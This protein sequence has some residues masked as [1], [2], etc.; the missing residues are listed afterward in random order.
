MATS[1]SYRLYRSAAPLSKRRPVSRVAAELTADVAGDPEPPAFA[2][3]GLDSGQGAAGQG[4]GTRSRRH[5]WKRVL[6]YAGGLAA[7]GALAYAGW[8]ALSI[9]QL[10]QRIYRPIPTLTPQQVAEGEPTTL[11]TLAPTAR[12]GSANGVATAA[13]TSTPDALAALPRGRVNILVLGTDKRANDPDHFPRSDTM[14]L[15]NLDTVSETVRVLSLPRD[16]VVEI[17]DYGRSKLN[18]AYLF[19]EYYDVPGGGQAVAVQTV[20]QLFNVPIDYYV[21]INFSGFRKVIDTVGGVQIDVPYEL[22]DYHYP[23]DDEGDPFGELHIHFDEGIQWMDGKTALRYARTR[24]ADNDFMRSRRQL[25]VI[26]ATRRAAMKLDLIPVFPRLIDDLAGTVETNIPF[27]QQLALA[28]LG[29]QIEASDIFTSTIDRDMIIP[30]TLPDG[31]E[32][33]ELDWKAAQPVVDDFFGQPIAAKKL[34]EQKVKSRKA[35]AT[36]RKGVK[37]PTPRAA[38]KATRTATATPGVR[39]TRTPAR[40]PLRRG[41]EALP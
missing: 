25:Q 11:P 32:G 5:T 13:A 36:P 37:T 29:Y 1:R 12:M 27:G 33:L 19:G 8:L 14:I 24:H 9:Y 7:L 4:I 10:E 40:T 26:L 38:A 6:R 28:Q 3:E 34:A 18:S 23:S 17:P 41:T 39:V 15:V 35:T 16:L 31:S 20:S 2:Q 22:D 30:T 21:A